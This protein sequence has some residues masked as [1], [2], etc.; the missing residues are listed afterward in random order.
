MELVPL[1]NTLKICTREQKSKYIQENKKSK[2]FNRNFERLR[3]ALKE[4][5]S[6]T[7]SGRNL[8]V[9]PSEEHDKIKPKD[10]ESVIK[11]RASEKSLKA[12][13]LDNKK[14]LEEK[15]TK[16][17]NLEKIKQILNKFTN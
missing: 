3:E 9:V 14:F 10:R 15:Q 6:V 17:A 5:K 7:F 13:E 1:N 4:K 16:L 12:L 11:F 2:V 8:Y